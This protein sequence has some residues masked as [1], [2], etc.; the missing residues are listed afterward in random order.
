[1]EA[2][3]KWTDSIIEAWDKNL[4]PMKSYSA[5]INGPSAAVQLIAKDG[6]AWHDE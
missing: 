2:A 3:W 5:G 1:M 6:R 4:T